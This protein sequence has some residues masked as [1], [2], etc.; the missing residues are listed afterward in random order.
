[1]ASSWEPI[2]QQARPL[3][4]TVLENPEVFEEAH[5][6]ANL[7]ISDEQRDKFFR[8]PRVSFACHKVAQS[9]TKIDTEPWWTMEERYPVQSGSR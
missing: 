9:K 1:V 2:E 7:P 3:F 4:N 5:W 6:L 8:L